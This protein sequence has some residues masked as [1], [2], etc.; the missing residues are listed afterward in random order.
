MRESIMAVTLAAALV[1]TLPAVAEPPD[2]EAEIAAQVLIPCARYTIAA[3][4]V[5]VLGDARRSMIERQVRMMMIEESVRQL[6]LF[7]TAKNAAHRQAIYDVALAGCID[8]VRK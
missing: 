7:V 8:A 4:G 5:D 3:Q 2:Y 1:L 6:V